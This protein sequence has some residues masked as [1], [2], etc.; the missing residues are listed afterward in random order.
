MTRKDKPGINEHAPFRKGPSQ[1]RNPKTP[2]GPGRSPQVPMSRDDRP[3]M[4]E[5]P[6]DD[7]PPQD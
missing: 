1:L 2:Q 4:P 5:R 7:L 6:V 3:I